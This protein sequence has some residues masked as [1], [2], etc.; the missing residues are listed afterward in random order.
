MT[1]QTKTTKVNV[2]AP[3]EVFNAFFNAGFE[4]KLVGQRMF[5]GLSNRAIS[6]SEA[7]DVIEIDDYMT[8]FKM[9]GNGFLEV[10]F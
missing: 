8:R 7:A 6:K 3:D 2:N 10:I 5:I 1:S 9:A 4:V